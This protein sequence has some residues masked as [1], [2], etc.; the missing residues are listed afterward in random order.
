MS[1][2]H[3]SL[4]L[5]DQTTAEPRFMM[6]LSM[7]EIT[8]FRWSLD[9]DV[10]NYLA[11]GYQAIGVWRHKLIDGDENQV[12]DLLAGS[13]L[14]VTNLTWAGG[15]TG[16]DGRTLAESV[17][18]AAD[19]LRLAAAL[20]AQS[21]VIYSGGR[22]NHTFRHAG[23][24]LR[25]ALDELLPLAETLE[26]PLAIEP[27]HP[28]CAADWTFLT[29]IHSALALIEEFSSPCLKLAYDTYHFPLGARQQHLLAR[30]APH[31]GI[32]HLADR[33]NAPTVEQ[34]RCPIGHGRLPLAL[35]ISTLQEA[36]YRGAFDVKLMGPEIEL[37][38]YWTM[39][40]QS[41]AAFNELAQATVSG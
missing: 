36:G 28:T 30:L 39:L 11:A 32:V 18:D 41:Q 29:D 15:F 4:H 12:I 9:E 35:I 21:L 6:M 31:L 26:V 3:A 10:E 7:N 40:E 38:D 19:A 24:L 34:E 27:M 20:A 17:D 13:G 22:N 2:T 1:H 33:R 16:S 5:V 8:T 25:T 37:C 14:H 23:R